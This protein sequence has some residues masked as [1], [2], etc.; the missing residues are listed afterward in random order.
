MKSA[1]IGTK[2]LMSFG[3]ALTVTVGV[4]VVSFLGIGSLGSSLHKVVT[5]N[6]LK[7]YL[8]SDINTTLTEMT[9][10][11]R[12]IMTR[13]F[14]KDRATMEQYD[15]EFRQ[16]ETHFQQRVAQ[17]I[18]LIET[19]QAREAIESL[20]AN[21][22][23][24]VQYHEQIYSFAMSGHTVESV[25]VFKDQAIPR[26]LSA[27]ATAEQLVTEQSALL[28]SVLQSTESSVSLSRWITVFMLVLGLLVGGGV[29]LLVGNINRTLRRVSIELS[30]GAE[31]TASAA[32]Q[33]SSTSQTMAQG[34]SEQAAS[35][36]ETSASG[37]EIHSMAQKNTE[38]TRHAAV[39]VAGS[40]QKFGATNRSLEQMVMAMDEIS[41]QS[42]KI[43]KIIHVIDE[44]AFQT[45]LL[46][47]NAAVEAARAGESGMGFA[48][49]ADEVRNLSQRCA[50]AAKDTAGLIE[51]SIAK[52]AHGKT[53]VDEVAA[54]MRDMARESAEIQRLVENVNQGSQ[55]QARGIEQI[56]QAIAQMERVT[57][58]AA[59]SAEESASAAEELSAQSETV[60]QIAG[61]LT[62]L[63]GK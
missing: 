53:K 55:E 44:I 40:Q 46:A 49:V 60:R 47:L 3:A 33:I 16:A 63:V 1:T 19:A 58:Q 56:A 48:V 43:S 27:R 14:M 52:S 39:L 57:Q 45:N 6:A 15:R 12:G 28:A 38:S 5:V 59:A 42:G 11:E 32:S 13:S 25:A 31:Q 17:F 41:T 61:R 10:L 37:E 35:L 8:A 7:R 18:P 26:L 20:Q 34:T 51:E 29:V 22:R 36:E 23:Q 4:C 21:E 62:A 54:A 2:L 50:Q 24:I 9:S 30:E